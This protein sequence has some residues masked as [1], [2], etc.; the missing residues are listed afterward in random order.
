MGGVQCAFDKGGDWH[1]AMKQEREKGEA[2]FEG[3]RK[4]EKT[5]TKK[6]SWGLPRKLLEDP[7]LD[8]GTEGAKTSSTGAKKEGGWSSEGRQKRTGWDGAE[9]KTFRREGRWS[10]KTR[11]KRGEAQ[12][13]FRGP[14]G[15]GAPWVVAEFKS[16]MGHWGK[17]PCD[18]LEGG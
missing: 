6:E 12:R 9:G 14:A 7:I 17:E 18:Q 13:R 10:K 16:K 3:A 2:Y 11:E 8:R 15:L 4:K 5:K 1:G